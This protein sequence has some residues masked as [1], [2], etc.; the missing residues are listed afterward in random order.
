MK[1]GFHG[2]T[3]WRCK[4]EIH[5]YHRYY[6]KCN[7][8]DD[9]SLHKFCAELCKML[10]HPSHPHHTLFLVP[11]IFLHVYFYHICNL[12]KRGHKPGE[13]FYQCGKCDFSID[14]RCAMEV[15]KN[16]I[17]HPCHPHLL[18]C[19]IPKPILCECSACGM[20]YKGI[21]YQC[22][23]CAGGFTIHSECAFLPKTLLIQEKKDGAFYHTHPL[24]ISYSFPKID[25]QAKHHPRC[26]VCGGYFIGQEDLW[27]YKCDK[28]MYYAHLY[29]ATSKQV[30]STGFG[31]TVKDYNDADYP[32]L[33]HL[34]FPDETYSIPKHLFFQ[35][36]RFGTFTS[37]DEV[38]L[39]NI[40]HEHP[41]ILVD[42]MQM[43]GKTSLNIYSWLLKCH[44]PVKKT[45]LL[46][47]GCLRPIMSTM[48]FYMCTNANDDHSCNFA[49]HE[50]CTRLP[51]E[52]KNHPVHPQ[53][54][55]H[56]IYSK[57]IPFFFGVFDCA[58]CY[59]PCNGFAYCCFECKYY[60][61]AHPNHLLSIVQKGNHSY[62]CCICKRHYNKSQP[63]FSCNSCDIYIHPECALLLVETIRHKYDKKHPMHLSY[64]PIENHKSEYLCEI[65]EE[66][67]NPHASFYHCQDCVQS[68]HTGCAPSI[69]QCETDTYTMY[70]GGVHV[71]INI[72]FG[73]IHNTNSHPHPLLFAQG[74]VLDGQCSICG[75]E[76]RYRLI[77]KCLECKFAIHYNCCS[78]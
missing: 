63:S 15:G 25:Q 41:L 37:N 51:G 74:I 24:I 78:L 67:L 31:H 55:L 11:Y 77:F 61:V 45:Q 44:D 36:T 4:E 58:A 50:W 39:Q 27:I 10:E 16:V 17:H 40:S 35:Q 72:K 54:T 71:F 7:I 30:S 12:C 66:D 64:I 65:C 38:S 18:T 19:A 29:C 9:F 46:C 47:N 62:V 56:L 6:Y 23:T 26:R 69:L 76:L 5:V 59:L 52:I 32:H 14:L 42:Q 57:D 49:L 60:V 13:L 53:H 73:S 75:N 48:P 28:C 22:S 34:P 2:I 33:F 43:D 3:C 1:E 20:E 8:C 70:Y 68:I 21:F